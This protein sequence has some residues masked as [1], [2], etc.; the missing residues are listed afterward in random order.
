MPDAKWIGLGFIALPALL[1][2]WFA[3]KAAVPF[4]IG[5]AAGAATMWYWLKK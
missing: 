3:I 5:A 1:L 2:L 4:A